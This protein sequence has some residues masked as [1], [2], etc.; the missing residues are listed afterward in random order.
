ML[1]RRDFLIGAG[2]AGLAA[3]VGALGTAEPPPRRAS[4]DSRC[5]RSRSM[6]AQRRPFALLGPAARRV[7]NCN[8]ARHSRDPGKSGRRRLADSLAW[9]DPALAAGR[10][11]RR[12]Q[13]AL[14]AGSSYSYRFPLTTPGTIGCIRMRGCRSS[15]SSSAPL[16]S[17]IRPSSPDRSGGRDPVA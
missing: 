9:L 12:V 5:A 11:A 15:N 7:C 10:R 13:A 1:N 4:R 14:A 8:S 2:A 17:T 16:T 3:A 6:A